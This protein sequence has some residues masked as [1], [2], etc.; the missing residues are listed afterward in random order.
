MQPCA[1]ASARDRMLAIIKLPNPIPISKRMF[2]SY[3][4]AYR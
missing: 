1:V 3:D 2:F 4:L